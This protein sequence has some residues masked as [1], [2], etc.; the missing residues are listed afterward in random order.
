MKK[1]AKAYI[2]SPLID[3]DTAGLWGEGNAYQRKTIYKI[4]NES[5]PSVNYDEHLLRPHSLPHAE[6]S[7]HTQADGFTI[8]YYFNHIPESFFGECLLL[9]FSHPKFSAVNPEGSIFHWI[10]SVDELKEK[11]KE[12]AGITY[13]LEKIAI[14]LSD[15][16]LPKTLNN[17]HDPN[18]VV[19]IS[20]EAAQFLIEQK[21]FNAFLTSWKSSDYRPGET[22]R[23][24]H[25]KLFERALIFECLR[26]F[27]VPE[28]RYFLSAFP[29]PLKG[30]SE[31]PCCPVFFE[32]D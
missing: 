14:T 1:A 9:K 28:G 27:G 30:A 29:L 5:L 13:S 18:Y 32:V 11:I 4:Q 22:A 12:V 26:F 8:D 23:P 25:N 31:S 21:S 19:T 7:K 24:I 3:E 16:V 2:L 6:G 15:D 17:T 20:E 10:I